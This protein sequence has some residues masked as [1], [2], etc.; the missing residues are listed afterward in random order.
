M[1]DPEITFRYES[2]LEIRIERE[3]AQTPATDELAEAFGLSVGDELTY[4]ITKAT[5]D[6]RP[7][8]ISDTYQPAGVI[9]TAEATVLEETVADRI[10]PRSMPNG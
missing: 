6:G 3:T 9:G 8:S 5:E 10:P 4:V 1:E 7:V 2:D